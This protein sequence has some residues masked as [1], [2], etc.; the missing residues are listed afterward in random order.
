MSRVVSQQVIDTR[1]RNSADFVVWE[2][3]K[4]GT[5]EPVSRTARDRL[6]NPMFQSTLLSHCSRAKASTLKRE[7][8]RITTLYFR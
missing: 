1:S 2:V 3:A 4:E 8:N 7:N 6:V 5:L